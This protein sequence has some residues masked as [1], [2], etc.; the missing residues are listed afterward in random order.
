LYNRIVPV[1]EAEKVS[2]LY[3][4][5]YHQ[6]Q[7]RTMAEWLLTLVQA[8]GVPLQVAGEAL[9]P[10]AFWQISFQ[11]HPVNNT[12]KLQTDVT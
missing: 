12:V 1:A 2:Q 5:H 8:Q 10:P 3:H 9:V 4:L 11:K 7:A 6:M